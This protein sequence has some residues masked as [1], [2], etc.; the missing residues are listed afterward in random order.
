[1]AATGFF[2][3]TVSRIGVALLGDKLLPGDVDDGGVNLTP[4]S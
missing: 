4:V 3:A 1:V 2:M